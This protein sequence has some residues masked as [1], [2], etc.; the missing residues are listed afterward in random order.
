[1]L[2]GLGATQELHSAKSGS[3]LTLNAHSKLKLPVAR[4]LARS[5]H[6]RLYASQLFLRV[7]AGIPTPAYYVACHSGRSKVVK[8]FGA[9][10]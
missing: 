2:G 5:W 10:L 1:M 6:L 9:L 4:T 7:I 3:V 8:P